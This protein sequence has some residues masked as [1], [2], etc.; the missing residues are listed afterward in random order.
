MK[1]ISV[2]PSGI[3]GKG[4]FADEDI[5]RGDIIQRINGRRIKRLVKSKEESNEIANWIGIG[6]YT[7]IDPTGTPFLYIN[8]SCEPNAAITGT[9]TLIALTD[10]SKGSEIYMDYSITDPDLFW[11]ISCNCGTPSC[12]K[13]IRS[14]HS[15]PTDV[16]RAHMPYV[17]RYFQKLFFRHYVRSQDS[18]KTKEV[19]E[20]HGTVSTS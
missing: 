14:I 10:I 12:R 13:T 1:K 4:I 3:H 20:K 15:V 16:F 7:W 6:K 19:V 2:Q 9:K 18:G 17:P 5:K 8:H 11:E